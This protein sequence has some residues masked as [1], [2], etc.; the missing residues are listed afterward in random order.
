LR[1]RFVEQ[2][3]ALRRRRDDGVDWRAVV[4]AIEISDRRLVRSQRLSNEWPVVRRAAKHCGPPAAQHLV[5]ERAR[6][7]CSNLV[8]ALKLIGHRARLFPA[9]S[10]KHNATER[11]L[12]PRSS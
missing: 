7:A 12:A 8:D 10:Q 6:L 9:S 5:D 1:I 4:E 2:P 11:A 3:P